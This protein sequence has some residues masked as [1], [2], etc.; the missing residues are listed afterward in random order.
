MLLRR[1]AIADGL[2]IANG[3]CGFAAIIVALSG[4]QVLAV[5]GQGLSQAR[6]LTCAALIV[7]GGIIDLFDGVV[8]RQ[9]GTS[10]LGT[11]LDAMSDILTF[12]VA[13][14]AVLIA[15]SVDQPIPYRAITIIAAALF[16]TAAMLRLA[17]HATNTAGHATSFCGLPV[18]PA[19]LA[20][21]A[22]I[23]IQPGPLFTL[24]T[25]ILLACLM[26]SEVPYPH[27]NL[28]GLVAVTL[29][30]SI[31]FAALATN[32]ISHRVVLVLGLAIILAPLLLNAVKRHSHL[33]TANPTNATQDAEIALITVANGSAPAFPPELSKR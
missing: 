5:H 27:P 19:S 17:R 31:S 22:V 18:P 29:Y 28:P 13:P 16:V 6:F 24:F 9:R 26:I 10:G 11:Q 3:L 15:S 21:L 25:V 1:M 2:T 8:A 32:L 14:A 7:A 20:T 12:A 4:T 30:L 33:A 23:H